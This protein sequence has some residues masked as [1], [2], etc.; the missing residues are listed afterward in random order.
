M[1]CL[2]PLMFAALSACSLKQVLPGTAVLSPEASAPFDQPAPS[3]A[4]YT[5]PARTPLLFPPLQAFGL[6][7]AVDVVLVTE[8][9]EWE[10]HEYARLD[11][12]QGSFWI[13]KD[14]A[15]GGTQTIVS[16][17]PDLKAWLPEIPIPRIQA[18]VTVQDHSSGARIDLNIAYTNPAGEP[19]EV[20]TK[21]RFP[22]AAPPK[23]NGNTMG[24]SQ[25][26]VAAVLDL[27]RMGGKVQAGV[28]INGEDAKLTRLLGLMPFKF[29]LQQTQ[30]GLAIAS[31]RVSPADSGFTLTRP[32]SPQEDW[33]T[34]ASESWAQAAT[35]A[36]HD[37]GIC[38][39]DLSFIEGG[40]S[41]IVVSQ[42]G[43]QTPVFTFLV[44]PALPDIRRPFT[45]SITSTFRMD[46]GDQRG[47][48]TGD[49]TVRWTSEDTVQIQMKPTAPHWLTD[50]PMTTQITFDPDG[51]A[52]VHTVRD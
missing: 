37:N 39:F 2:V 29:L 20:W 13:A 35:T 34:Q 32:A 14:A 47:H 38:A 46:V 50:R 41:K 6:Q 22:S 33:P 27:Q 19:V 31:Y 10:M 40:L 51:T 1:R 7:Y 9:P 52:T 23:R 4:E 16:D 5:G 24:H 21:G 28:R 48:G 26:I 15:T 8:H 18:P 3:Q 44:S 11:T 49:V 25:S 12:P 42:H 45:G 30:G 43:I 36:R 17:V